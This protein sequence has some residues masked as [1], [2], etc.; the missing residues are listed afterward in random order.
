[1]EEENKTKELD[2]I[3]E[4][5]NGR[6]IAYRND[7]SFRPANISIELTPDHI[8]EYQRC[9]NDICYF[10]N[11]KCYINDLNKG[12]SLIS[13]WDFQKDVLN[14]MI[15]ERFIALN[16]SRQTSKTTMT[17]IFILWQSI[18]QND[19]ISAVLANKE[20]TSKKIFQEIVEMYRSL[21]LW[22]KP[23]VMSVNKTEIILDNNSKIFSSATSASAIRGNSCSLIYIDECAFVPGFTDFFSS[24]YPTVSSSKTSKV[25]LSSTPC[26]LNHWYHIVRQARENKSLFKLKEV[27]WYQ[28]PGR[29]EKWK[30]IE[31]RNTS[32]AQ[33]DQEYSLIFQG[34]SN[35]IVS[36]DV[37]RNI[38]PV[39]PI[40]TEL[41][42]DLKVYKEPEP[43]HIYVISCDPSTGMGEDNSIGMVIDVT[44]IKGQPMEQVALYKSSMVSQASLAYILVKIAK[45]YNNCIIVIENNF[46]SVLG[47]VLQ[48]EIGYDN[49][50]TDDSKQAK[51]LNKTCGINLTKKNKRVGVMHLT[52]VLNNQLLKLCCEEAI[53]ELSNFV[54]RKDS[55]GSSSAELH[56]DVVMSLV[57]FCVFSKTEYFKEYAENDAYAEMVRKN[58]GE[59]AGEDYVPV[60]INVQDDYAEGDDGD[61][62][63]ITPDWFK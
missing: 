57:L 13:L 51:L 49:L 52:D 40:R 10:A 62:I 19:K 42:G 32:Q 60:I 58:L 59:I 16:C 47:E 7:P 38:Y 41:N 36:S 24:V 39:T 1:M 23:G 21:P 34:S 17:S 35:S 48:N 25:I 50:Y 4:D 22:M 8:L 3:F 31:I 26:G 46:G 9:S 55:W 63:A 54:R 44:C 53:E 12:K 2:D 14:M 5:I 30:E 33:F 15:Q 61:Y 28:V 18:F 6:A 45:D 56:D 11:T 20:K 29:D 27:Y 43:G 37:I